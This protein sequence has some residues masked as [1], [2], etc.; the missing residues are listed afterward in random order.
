MISGN[1][2]IYTLVDECFEFAVTDQCL[3]DTLKRN[4]SRIQLK[5]I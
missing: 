1:G 5:R 2:M 4:I 3:F